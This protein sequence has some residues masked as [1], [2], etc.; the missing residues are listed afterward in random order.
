MDVLDAASSVN[1]P[2]VRI[3]FTM[4]VDR[5]ITPS[6]AGIVRNNILCT[7]FCTCF[8]NS[9]LSPLFTASDK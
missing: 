2:P 6:I 9:F 7:V 3:I 4:S 5:I 1:S 8:V